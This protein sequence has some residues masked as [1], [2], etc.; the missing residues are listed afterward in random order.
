MSEMKQHIKPKLIVPKAGQRGMTEL[1]YAAY[2]NSPD[3]VRLQL[4]QGAS[5]DVRDDVGWTPLHWSIDM[6]QAWGEP[7]QVVS[8]L[9]AAGASANAVDQSGFSV[10]MMAC[11]RNNTMIFEQLIKA[12]ADI[13]S[14]SASG[15]TALHEA[16]GSNFSEAIRWLLVLGADP[17]QTDGQNRTPE[18]ISERCGFDQ[19]LSVFKAARHGT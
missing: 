15:A 16:A 3:A 6:A 5:V 13:H 18:E 2:C 9:L 10:L 11:G 7:Q 19:S 12:G 14:R 17:S 1:H 4:Q 8:L